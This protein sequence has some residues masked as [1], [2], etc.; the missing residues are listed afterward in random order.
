MRFL[1]ACESCYFINLYLV[2]LAYIFIICAVY[3]RNNFKMF[4]NL[5]SELSDLEV[6]GCNELWN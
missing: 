1:I 5:K 3:E 6:V 2:L 4:Y